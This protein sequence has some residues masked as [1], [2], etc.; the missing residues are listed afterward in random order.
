M[1][2]ERWPQIKQIVQQALE[3]EPGQRTVYLAEACAGDSALLLEIE[4]LLAAHEKSRKFLETLVLEDE[5]NW[6]TDHF[7]DTAEGTRISAY[8]ILHEIGHGGMGTVYLGS[9]IR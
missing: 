9:T 1:T 7:P 8:Q 4:S 5:T 2:P 6:L 3:Y